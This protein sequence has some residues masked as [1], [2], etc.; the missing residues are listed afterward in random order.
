MSWQE[1]MLAVIGTIVVGI[2]CYWF[3]DRD[4]LMLIAPEIQVHGHSRTN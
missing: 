2:L 1:W 4:Q 3:D